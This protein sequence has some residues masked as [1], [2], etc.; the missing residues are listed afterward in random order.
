MYLFAHAG[1]FD[2]RSGWSVNVMDEYEHMYPETLA[3]AEP[4]NGGKKN[5]R[6]ARS[7]IFASKLNRSAVAPKVNPVP[8]GP[9]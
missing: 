2:E 8:S 5:S 9:P 3:S 7:L 1:V 4:K 6:H